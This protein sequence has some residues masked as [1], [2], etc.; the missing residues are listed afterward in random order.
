[1]KYINL[2][3]N[4]FLEV[5]SQKNLEL[6]FQNWVTNDRGE[7][8]VLDAVNEMCIESLSPDNFEKWDEIKKALKNSRRLLKKFDWTV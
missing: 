8:S 7:L 4:K 2:D 1:M 3:A 6:H 5:K